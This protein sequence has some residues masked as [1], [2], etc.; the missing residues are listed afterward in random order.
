MPGGG[1]TRAVSNHG[2]GV[3]GSAGEA[4]EASMLGQKAH[5][6]QYYHLAEGGAIGL[7]SHSTQ[8]CL[9]LLWGGCAGVD[10]IWTLC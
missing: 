5:A 6:R 7:W 2:M 8:T 3:G 1:N 9:D 10:V 4:E